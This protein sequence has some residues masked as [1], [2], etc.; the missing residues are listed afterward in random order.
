[1]SEQERNKDK[2]DLYLNGIQNNTKN[3]VD[4]LKKELDKLQ[5]DII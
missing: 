1:M 2:I 3:K 5:H 4:K